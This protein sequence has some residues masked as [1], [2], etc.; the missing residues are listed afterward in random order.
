[1]GNNLPRPHDVWRPQFSGDF[2]D[3]I[4][5]DP[6]QNAGQAYSFGQPSDFFEYSLGAGINTVNIP[7]SETISLA[8]ALPGQVYEVVV[9]P[10][11]LDSYAVGSNGNI[12][13]VIATLPA[14]DKTIGQVKLGDL[15]GYTFPENNPVMT[16]RKFAQQAFSWVNPS[17]SQ[18]Y[19]DV[20]DFRM[21]LTLVFAP[22]AL[23]GGYTNIDFGE[24][25]TAD[26]EAPIYPGKPNEIGV[27]GVRGIGELHN[28]VYPSPP[29][30]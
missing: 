15:E 11:A 13:S 26:Q 10:F 5:Y 18:N 12:L 3:A 16:N 20:I 7:I 9:G 4:L 8:P 24:P 21:V 14:G 27:F 2:I 28:C 22:V 30:I 19:V 25:G 23:P 29:P 6:T 17:G 1:M